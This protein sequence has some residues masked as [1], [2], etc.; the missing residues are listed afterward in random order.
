MTCSPV[1]GSEFTQ[2]WDFSLVHIFHLRRIIS[3][4]SAALRLSLPLAPLA[5]NSGSAAAP[6]QPPPAAL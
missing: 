2:R 4:Y 3:I 5:P 6:L 1:S